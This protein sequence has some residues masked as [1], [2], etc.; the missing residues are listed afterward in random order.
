MRKRN[1][2]IIGASVVAVVAL[3]WWYKAQKA[4]LSEIV[5]PVKYGDFEIS[6]NAAG[7][8]DPEKSTVIQGPTSLGGMDIWQ[9][10]IS[11]LVPEGTIVKAGDEVAS[12]DPTEV[13]TKLKERQTDLTKTQAQFT[14]TELDTSLTLRQAR[15][16]LVNLKFTVREK[17]INLEQSRFEPPATIRQA[18]MDVDKAK[19]NLQQAKENYLIKQKQAA[20]KMEEVAATRKTVEQKVQ[21][22]S[23][24]I[25]KLKIKTPEPGM[26]IYSRDWNGRKRIVGTAIQTWNPTVATLPDLS[27]MLSKTFINE[28]EVRKVVPGQDVRISLDAFPEKKLTGKVLSVANMGEQRP[29]SDAKVFEVKIKVNETD[30]SLRPAM[31]T[32]NYIVSGKLKN[33]LYVPLEALHNQGDSI[34][35]VFRKDGASLSRLQVLTGEKNESDAVILKGLTRTDQVLLNTPLKPDDYPLVL[36]PDAPKNAAPAKALS[37][38]AAQ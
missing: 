34:I 19:R 25:D 18:E 36:L 17:E 11:T 16:E 32:G 29:N 20:A 12:L 8:L 7:E 5:V 21:A 10:K 30:T 38:S 35:Y 24:V 13:L 4:P 15:D 14:Q 37:L 28:V 31:T 27:V 1:L 6:V 23:D 26:V 33:V 9:I 3:I 22:I 2:Y